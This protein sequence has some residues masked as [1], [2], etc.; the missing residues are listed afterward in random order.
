MAKSR[1][2]FVIGAGPVGLVTALYLAKAGSSVRVYEGR[3]DPRKV[4]PFG[5]R[6]INLTIAARGWKA[7]ADVGAESAVRAISM[8]LRGRA[9]HHPDGT[10]TTQPYGSR[11]ESIS[12]VSRMRLTRTLI[13]VAEAHPNIKLHFGHRLVQL[14]AH[15]GL[16]ELEHAERGTAMNMRAELL[17]AADGA[18]S[19]ARSSLLRSRSTEYR[20]TYSPLWYKEL[21]IPAR[22]DWPLD[23]ERTHVWP[24]RDAILIAFPNLDRSFTATLFLRVDGS[25]SF[26]ELQTR[27][28]L[29]VL[30]KRLFADVLP[31]APDLDFAFFSRPITPLVSMRC[32]PW[33]WSGRFALIGDAA[34]TMVP[35][36]GQGMNAGL[37]DCTV[38]AECMQRADGD[39]AKMLAEYESRRKP[40]CDMVTSLAE[41]HYDELA[42]GVQDPTALLRRR[43]EQRL[44]DQD[45]DRFSPLYNLISFTHL[46]Y[47]RLPSLVARQEPL[48]DALVALP[49]VEQR[50]DS[51]V[52]QDL[53]REHVAARD[54]DS[55]S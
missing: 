55:A 9:I 46:P 34:H 45:P 48:V 44:H 50:W 27:E 14:D 22:S 25:P 52:V 35:F 8:P 29:T 20:Q 28:D 3:P 33:T 7:L 15:T 21:Q 42:V 43:I 5:G 54:H 19:A 51:H 38:L 6:S 39:R 36:L 23:P 40:D 30:F 41:R 12:A 49:D 47:A 53:V 1:D 4:R 11:G 17:F 2:A 10:T 26:R 37:E 32:A 13:Q 31:L 18:Y 16:L 24:R